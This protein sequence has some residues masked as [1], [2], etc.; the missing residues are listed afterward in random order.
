MED[1]W[2]KLP[3]KYRDLLLNALSLY[4]R[5]YLC[6]KCS[7]ISP[8]EKTEECPYCYDLGK[9]L[10]EALPGAITGG[11]NRPQ[12]FDPDYKDWMNRHRK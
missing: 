9:R 4:N 12:L 6:T 8:N 2:K 3:R 5:A 10:S 11:K 1:D 7:E